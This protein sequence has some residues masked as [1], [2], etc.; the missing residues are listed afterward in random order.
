MA[1]TTERGYGYNHARRRDHLL[2][3]H[4]DGTECDYCGRPMYR[5]KTKNFDGQALNADHKDADK[6]QLAGRL[7]HGSCNKSMNSAERWVEH[8][9]EWYAKHG[10]PT[11]I[12]GYELDWPGGQPIT[13]PA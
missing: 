2:Y 6:T 10:Q 8:G 13:W 9:P 11:T 12:A 1:T 3:N 5:D 4:V 7:L